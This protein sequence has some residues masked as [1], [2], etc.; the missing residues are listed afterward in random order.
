MLN[1]HKL[2][3]KQKVPKYILYINFGNFLNCI[4]PSR[5][6]LCTC[7]MSI[8]VVAYYITYIISLII[9]YAKFSTLFIVNTEFYHFST[10]WFFHLPPPNKQQH[11]LFTFCMELRDENSYFC[12][13]RLR[14]I[15]ITAF[16]LIIISYNEYYFLPCLHIQS[17]YGIS[18]NCNHFTRYRFNMVE[19]ILIYCS[20][21]L[22][23]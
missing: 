18:L 19:I 22:I 11:F 14:L 10:T 5:S 2:F 17:C 6:N 21:M 12:Q 4:L 7:I 20:S 13:S 16:T 1:L 8:V 3:V 9:C 23:L 15:V